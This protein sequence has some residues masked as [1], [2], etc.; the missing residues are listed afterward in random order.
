MQ[1]AGSAMEE[2]SVVGIKNSQGCCGQKLIM[3]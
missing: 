1:F 2:S 3:E